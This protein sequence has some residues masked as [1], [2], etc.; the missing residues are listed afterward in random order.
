MLSRVA[1]DCKKPYFD[2]VDSHS[3]ATLYYM[4]ALI[5]KYNNCIVCD[6]EVR[7]EDTKYA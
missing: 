6:G 7:L 4:L 5:C 1:I 3:H 2:N